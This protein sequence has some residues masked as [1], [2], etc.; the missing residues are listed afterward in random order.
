MKLGGA[1]RVPA[2]G[3][4]I[5]PNLTPLKHFAG[6]NTEM[7][8]EDEITKAI[9]AHG[10]WKNRLRGAIDSGKADANPADVAK[11]N[12]CPFGQWLQ[13]ST[14]TASMR[15]GANY[16]AVKKLHAD[17][18]RCASNVMTCVASGKK[19]QAT[20]LLGGEFSKISGELTNAMMKWKA[21]GA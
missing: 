5:A 9:G 10:M 2:Y 20:S 11:D 6:G 13:G 18:H 15:N 8:L 7:A 12:A 21:A 14:I 3:F 4:G 16:N 17:F 19:E 1:D